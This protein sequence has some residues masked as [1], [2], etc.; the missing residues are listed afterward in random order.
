MP[1]HRYHEIDLLKCIS[2]LLVVYAHAVTTSFA[3]SKVWYISLARD[4][5]RFAVPAL[6]FTSGFLF[7]KGNRT[8]W[9]IIKKKLWRILPP[10]LFCS[11]CI[12]FLDLPKTSIPLGQLSM[13]QFALNLVAGNTIGIYYFIFV[14]FYLY[15]FSLVFRKLPVKWVWAVWLISLLCL[16]LFVERIYIPSL[17]L[18]YIIPDNI[19]GFLMRHPFY[20]FFPYMT[21]WMISLYYKNIC[22]FVDANAIL[23]IFISASFIVIFHLCSNVFGEGLREF[24]VIDQTTI[25]LKICLFFCVGIKISKSTAVVRYFSDNTFGIYLVHF[26]IVK[27]AQASLAA[28]SVSYLF[29]STVMSWTAAVVLSLVIIQ[30]FKKMAGRYSVYFI[31]S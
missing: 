2:I 7:D 22:T 18:N 8:T 13:K 17:G 15:A 19:F 27:S 6:F 10:Y 14:L 29:L 25:Y 9:Q 11:V 12:Q 23:A 1:K 16:W 30:F 28:Y 26:P 31:G 3:P 21:G 5:G 24:P 4:M 20:W